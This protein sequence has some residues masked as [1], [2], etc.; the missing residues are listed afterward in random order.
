MKPRVALIFTLYLGLIACGENQYNEVTLMPSPVAFT[1][2]ALDPFHGH[3]EKELIGHTTLFYATDRAPATPDDASD[4]YANRRGHLLRVGVATVNM[5]PRIKSWA[6]FKDITLAENREIERTLSVT[7]VE[8]LGPLPVTSPNPLITPPPADTLARVHRDFRDSINRQLAASGGQDAVIYVHGYNVDFEYP[9]LISQELQ[10]FLGYKGAFISYNW[11][12]TPRRT[13]YFKDLETANATR[14]NLRVLIEF[15]AQETDVRRIHLIGYSA[16]S[17]LAFEATYQ[18]A[19]KHKSNP[20]N[21]KLGQVILV[22]SDLDRTYFAEAIGDGLL[23]IMDHLSIYM[24]SSDSALGMSRLVFG[25][26]R[27]GQIG[28][29]SEES[30]ALEHRLIDVP[31]VSLIDVTDAPGAALGNGHWY[32]R[33]SPWTSSDIFL[34]LLKGSPPAKRGLERTPDSAVWHFPKDYPDRILRLSSDM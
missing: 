5:T 17:R 23:D 22:G 2:G 25:R 27:L 31:K 9:T 14:K 32:F 12:A 11:A 26:H 16:G 30:R 1:S 34:S 20:S 6:E 13:A 10:H 15:L 3:G 29:N 33:S 4:F 28:D 19:L 18:L 21:A 7:A 24:S 8:E